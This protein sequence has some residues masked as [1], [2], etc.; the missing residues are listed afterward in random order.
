M[1][2]SVIA[3]RMSLSSFSVTPMFILASAVLMDIGINDIL[4][5]ILKV[6]TP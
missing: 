2:S 4:V 5:Y 6:Y 1:L 3:T